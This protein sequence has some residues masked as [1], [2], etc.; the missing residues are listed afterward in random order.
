VSGCYKGGNSGGGITVAAVMALVEVVVAA[1][2]VAVATMTT[3]VT[4]VVVAFDG[5]GETSIK[6][7]AEL[8]YQKG[9]KRE[10]ETGG[11]EEGKG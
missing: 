4:I 1:G 5:M 3:D 8:G 6:K 11:R 10:R 7:R 9:K 2:M